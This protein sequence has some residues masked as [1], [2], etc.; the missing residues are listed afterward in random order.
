MP[1]FYDKL[2]TVVCVGVAI[3]VAAHLISAGQVKLQKKFG[4]LQ[5]QAIELDYAEYNNTTGKWQWKDNKL[6]VDLNELG[7]K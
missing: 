7:N 4:D 6:Q 1:S 3:F 5:Q 2:V